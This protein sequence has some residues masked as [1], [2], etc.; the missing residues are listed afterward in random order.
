[1][2]SLILMISLL[3][4]ASVNSGSFIFAGEANGVGIVAHPQ[5]Y[6]GAGG[7]LNISVCIDPASTVT[8][9]LETSVTN[10]VHTW[11]QLLVTSP[12]LFLGANNNIGG[13]QFDWESVALHEVGH[14]IG[15]A[16]PNLG[17]QTGV[18]G[19]NTNYTNST[20]GVDNGFDFGFGG[21]G[22]RG[23]NDD[24]RDDDINLHWYNTGV[25]NPFIVSPPYDSSN[26]SMVLA[27]LPGGHN[28]PANADRTVGSALGF[29]NT[30]AVMQQGTFNDEGQRNLGADDV[31]TLRLAMSGV[32][33]VQGNADDYTIK[34]F[35]GGITA[36]CD[37]NILHHPIG[38]LAFCQA[39]GAF[40]GGSNISITT[41]SIE[42]NS[43]TN[44][45]FNNTGDLIFA[46]GF[47]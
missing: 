21:D 11:N 18:T 45:F 5:G 40:V 31:S 24:V 46:N 29:T 9:S 19:A 8:T 30:E 13:S 15:L 26:Y 10:V 20:D 36:G 41:A 2:K 16:H 34:L 37:I 25:N 32:D 47:E 14:C 33:M 22:I 3:F 7:T 35:Y 17:S 42:I 1:M 43:G 44:W 23:S 38:G 39:G 4:S 27:D 12:N 6:T 28:Y